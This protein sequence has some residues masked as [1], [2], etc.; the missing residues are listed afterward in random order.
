M[1]RKKLLTPNFSSRRAFSRS[2]PSNF[3]DS[4]DFPRFV[5]SDLSSLIYKNVLAEKY[6]E[7]Y[8]MNETTEQIEQSNNNLV[9]KFDTRGNG[10]ITTNFSF[11]DILINRNEFKPVPEI[12]FS[13][14]SIERSGIIPIFFDN[15]TVWLGFMVGKLSNNISIIGGTFDK[16]KDGDLLST[17]MR[18]FDEEMHGLSRDE[19]YNIPNILISEL[20]ICYGIVTNSAISIFY[21]VD[22]KFSDNYF[23]ETEETISMLWVTLDQMVSIGNTSNSLNK[24]F[25]KLG[26]KERIDRYN[27]SSVF[28]ESYK[29]ISDCVHKFPKKIYYGIEQ[30]Y[31]DELFLNGKFQI[32]EDNYYILG[33]RKLRAEK[34]VSQKIHD[35]DDFVLLLKKNKTSF[36]GGTYLTLTSDIIGICDKYLTLFLFKNNSSN[37]ELIL[38]ILLSISSVILLPT[39]AD[40]SFLIRSIPKSF[41]YDSRRFRSL[42]KNLE[43]EILLSTNRN[44]V[45]ELRKLLNYYGGR[46]KYIEKEYYNVNNLTFYILHLLE[47][48]FY[49]DIDSFF[50]KE[51]FRIEIPN[52]GRKCYYNG[53]NY[54]NSLMIDNGDYITNKDKEQ[55]FVRN[56]YKTHIPETVKNNYEWDCSQLS[57]NEL[58]KM[59]K[60]DH[61]IFETD[62]YYFIYSSNVNNL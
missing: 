39:E 25:V 34:R 58:I 33:N 35:F 10:R 12:D 45:Y 7:L 20:S 4:G 51:E 16:K 43:R 32:N 8:P 55:I 2:S 36:S 56:L 29:F 3:N 46:L 13:D 22:S 11:N 19:N 37:I 1:D 38:K 40:V 59:M 50:I 23:E 9:S 30:D 6:N 26:S 54:I 27:L 28:R 53:I 48:T 52:S 5:Q 15:G 41:K 61:L 21:P 62:K 14:P 18:E 17:A 31:A 47:E 44:Y 57:M 42:E 49:C 60:E 24:K